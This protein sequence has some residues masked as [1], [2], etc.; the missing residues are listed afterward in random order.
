MGAALRA[1]I[2]AVTL[3]ACA[4]WAV[5]A[6]AATTVS[7]SNW[8]GYAARRSG[9]TFRAVSG[10]WTVPTVSCEPVGEAWSAVW[11]G[12]GGYAT[13]SSSLAQ[14]GTEA[15]CADGQPQ[16]SAW[17]ELVPD[18]SHTARLTVR[19]GDQI[20][21]SVHATSGV[22]QMRLTDATT[23]ATYRKTLKASHLDR[24]SAEWIVEAPSNCSSA[25]GQCVVMPLA[26]FNATR[27]GQARATTTGGYTGGIADPHWDPVAID[28]R[29]DSGR[30]MRPGP[31]PGLPG[32]AGGPD[33][34]I[35]GADATPSD[36][37]SSGNAFT[38]TYEDNSAGTVPTPTVPTY[39][40]WAQRD[41]TAGSAVH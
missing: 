3:A 39:T 10:S 35:G 11:V 7:S 12:I 4:F 14:A 34:G 1:A 15:D 17:Y 5:P 38:V 37:E 2:A 30:Q 27:I 9:V 24:T 41:R 22:V 16:Y 32:T 36:L 13:T 40:G 20:V 19:P 31:I 33:V 25:G 18:A 21:A 28:L 26:N 8:A 23:G 6:S 29:A